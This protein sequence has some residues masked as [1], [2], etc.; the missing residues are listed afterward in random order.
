VLA[1]RP[2]TKVL[3]MTGYL[4]SPLDLG[5]LPAGVVT[6][7]KPVDQAEL[8]SAVREALDRPLAVPAE[9]SSR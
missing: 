7:S 9:R 4:E 2:G 3:F 8:L 1:D 5:G 6:L